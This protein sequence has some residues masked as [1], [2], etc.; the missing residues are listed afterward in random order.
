MGPMEQLLRLQF[1]MVDKG[2]GSLEVHAIRDQSL[3][4]P[5]FDSMAMDVQ[6]LLL[7]AAWRIYANSSRLDRP[8][9]VH[10]LWIGLARR[11]KRT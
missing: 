1:G 3:E 4:R 11:L 8:S 6:W 9:L 10:Q 5:M 2:T 7:E